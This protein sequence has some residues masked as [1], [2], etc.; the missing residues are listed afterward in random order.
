MS[1]HSCVPEIEQKG[2]PLVD[3][4]HEPVGPWARIQAVINSVPAEQ[5]DLKRFSPDT[6]ARD[7]RGQV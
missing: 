6:E 5:K 4:P 3:R 2:E 7:I 1:N